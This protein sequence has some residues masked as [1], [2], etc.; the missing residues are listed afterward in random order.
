[1]ADFVGCTDVNLALKIEKE[2]KKF[3]ISILVNNVGLGLARMTSDSD[4]DST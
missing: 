4:M 2:I 1:M 3:D